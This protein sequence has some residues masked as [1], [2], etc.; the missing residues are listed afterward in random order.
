MLAGSIGVEMRE[1]HFPGGGP[2]EAYGRGGFRFAGM[3]HRGSLMCLPSG[4]YAWDVSA[5][6]QLSMASFARAIAESRDIE[7]LLVGTGTDIVPLPAEWRSE[8]RALGMSA[9]AMTTGAAVRTLNV[10]LSEGR[11]VAAAMIAVDG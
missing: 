8:F 11:A 3:S 10:L 9:D 7:V 2:I 5:A 4:I 1:G 6:G